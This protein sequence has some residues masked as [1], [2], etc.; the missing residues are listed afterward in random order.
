MLTRQTKR[1]VREIITVWV[2]FL[3]A[4]H[5]PLATILAAP[6][7]G[8]FA[9]GQGSIQQA[10]NTT[11]ITCSDRSVINWGGFNI[12]TSEI[13]R[14]IQPGASAAV[15]NRILSGSVTSI[16]GALFANGRVF[17]VNPAGIIFGRG[18]R[19]NV[20]QLVASALN[21][22]DADFIK[23][24]Y[25]FVGGK[26]SVIN[27]GDIS[28]EK[29]AL[30]GR[31]VLN[32]GTIRCPNGYVILAAGDRVFLNKAGTQVI[33]ELADVSLPSDLD[34]GPGILNET[35]GKIDVGAGTITLAA[36]DIYSQAISNVGSLAASVETG[37]AGKVVLAAEAGQVVNSGSIEATSNSGA[38]GSVQILGDQVGIIETA[39]V[40][41]SGTDGGG[42]VLVG[43]D[44]KGQGEVRNALQTYVGKD[45]VINA[46][47]TVSGDGGKVIVWADD[48]TGFYGNISAR[49]GELGGDGGFAE[50]SG[51]NMLDFAGLVDLQAPVGMAGIL[52]LDPTNITIS[53]GAQDPTMGW[54]NGP[55]QFYDDTV[56]SSVLNV[57]NLTNQL[58]LSRVEVTT[59]GGVNPGNVGWIHVEDAI[60]WNSDK[61]LT[62]TANDIIRIS[63]GSGGITNNGTGALE[64]D[65]GSHVRVNDAISLNGGNFKSSGDNFITNAGGTITTNGG[66]V[67]LT[68]HTGNVT[69]KDAVNTGGGNFRSGGADF[70]AGSSPTTSGTITTAGGNVNLTAHTGEVKIRR[71]VDTGGGAFRSAGTDFTST[72]TGT[73]TTSGGNVNLSA[74]SGTVTIGETIDT[75]GGVGDGRVEIGGS[76][77]SVEENLTAKGDL[78]LNSD[79]D[80][81]DGRKLDAGG[82][83]IVAAGKQLTGQ[84]VLTLEA[85]DNLTFGGLV[86]AAADLWLSADADGDGT[87]TV[88]VGGTLRNTS[89]NI[90]ISASDST[91]DID[92][93]V[94]AAQDL[95]LNNYTKVADG[96]TLGAGGNVIV[97]AGKTLEVEGAVTVEAGANALFGGA[98]EGA[99]GSLT[100]N[101]PGATV[102]GGNIGDSGA[103]ASLQTDSPGATV[104]NGDTIN[105]DGSSATFGDP[106][107][108]TNDLTINELGAGDV[109]FASTVDS[110]VADNYTLTVNTQAGSTIFGGAV[111]NDAWGPLSHDDG[112][113][114][115]TTNA[116]GS[117]QINGGIVTTTGAQTYN[118]VVT[119]GA[120]ATVLTG[121]GVEFAQTV[122]GASD[123]TVNTTGGGSTIF[124][125]AVGNGVALNSLE[126]NADGDTQI[127][128]GIVTT[129]GDQTYNDDVT[130]VAGSTLKSGNDIAAKA[131]LQGLGAL[132]IE[133]D[134]HI[135]LNENSGSTTADGKLTLWADRDDS[136]GVGGG[137]MHAYSTL[138]TTT[139][140]IE[141]LASDST[142][143]LDDHVNAAQDL[144]LRNNTVVAADKKLDAGRDVVLA[145]GKTLTGEGALTVEADRHVTLGGA[146]ESDGKL[147]LTAD[148]DSDRIGK[149]WAKSTLK[150]TAGDIEISA[151]D[152][153]PF[154]LFPQPV[155]LWELLSQ[156]LTRIQLDD[157]VTASQ[158]L[159]LNNNTTVAAG[160][161]LAAGRDII[162][163]PGKTVK[164]LGDLILWAVTG[165]VSE[166]AG[167]DGKAQIWMAADNKT[168]TLL[169]SDEINVA[170]N[171]DVTNSQNTNLIATSLL[172]LGKLFLPGG[173]VIS[174]AADMWGSTTATAWNNVEL[175]GLND[176]RIGGNLVSFFGGVSVISRSGKIYTGGDTFDNVMVTGTSNGTTG[177]LLPYSTGPSDV[178]A[179]VMQSAKDLKLGAGATFM[180]NGT[181]NPAV[182]DRPG[183]RFANDG[184]P[185]DVAAYFGSTQNDVYLNSSVN[186][187]NAT[188]G[189]LVVDAY[190]TVH[191]FGSNF[192]N[193]ANFDS[194][195][196]LE[197]VSRITGSLN[198]A[199]LHKT[200][201]YA[202]DPDRIYTW[203][204]GTYVL[205]GQDPAIVLEW[206]DEFVPTVPEGFLPETQGEPAQSL[207][208][209]VPGLFQQA[210][211]ELA[212]Q[213]VYTTDVWIP[214][215]VALDI[216]TYH[217]ALRGA[218]QT[219]LVSSL[220]TVVASHWPADVPVLPP[221]ARASIVNDLNTPEY[222]SV[223]GWLDAFA[224]FYQLLTT[225]AYWEASSATEVMLGYL[226]PDATEQVTD[227]IAL[228]FGTPET[229]I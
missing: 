73:I 88:L 121:S 176:I 127:N 77:I 99:G 47:A 180:V 219:A 225:E 216:V 33:V 109:E 108:L 171:F 54:Y 209:L 64:F 15:L 62:L 38:G 207:G 86:E 14:F 122:D 137:D 190:D 113:G 221:E 178:A 228:Y 50:V 28:A 5:V 183:V 220:S 135:S 203:F 138:A 149:M 75:S 111:G 151:S 40:D 175:S 20:N 206:L 188:N 84:G 195:N 4:V 32:S 102:F 139:G 218:D 97:A 119:L 145:D 224:G 146:T 44:Y 162:L 170:D 128:G 67:N 131:N 24:N 179:I 104:I 8:R 152:G 144:L 199:I 43:G 23:G 115:V 198:Y 141:I 181:Y 126:T 143:D 11:T 19:V 140:D 215:A 95:L 27:R 35:G 31:Q 76:S 92:A 21:I 114:A 168:L 164:A 29:V 58:N 87:G 205:R 222:A 56:A 12:A 70:T 142:I 2:A 36:G 191:P 101:S 229:A 123:L 172:I 210:Y 65:A 26:G 42:E 156:L 82:S 72:G 48:A 212:Y 148:A 53:N 9:H 100:V 157:N 106:V 68:G 30:I 10:G 204:P 208:A 83:L 130:A 55:K 41:V 201:P 25:S 110:S 223:K 132:T 69:I 214:Y 155:P 125:G 134:R 174:T 80:I 34:A 167:H 18:A 61:K 154:A 177:V 49:G 193:G 196:R 186:M 89:G 94:E 98:V 173:A 189:T 200:L 52:L 90:N 74:H 187:T 96:Q 103:L 63:T 158:D 160:K 91:I 227:F 184:E 202:D 107:L 116:L 217:S 213:D 211:L 194:T 163:G 51:K 120:P 22:S 112:L 150:T 85:D 124:G 16:D 78:L 59:D 37:D 93:S 46:D 105:L 165:G 153:W 71:A 1:G 45:A 17:L 7:G 118:D 60:V 147:T 6:V 185:I 39:K 166:A 133:A 66:N 169:Q 192:E 161:T 3:I 117:T 79:T 57:T 197:V 136:G 182:D 226:P 13:A 159:L 129:T 81:A